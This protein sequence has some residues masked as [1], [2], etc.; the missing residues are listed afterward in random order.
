MLP[1]SRVPVQPPGRTSGGR[2]SASRPLP[3]HPILRS[4]YPG[5]CSSTPRRQGASG[6]RGRSGCVS[7]PTAQPILVIIFGHAHPSRHLTAPT[8]PLVSNSHPETPTTAKTRPHPEDTPLP[9]LSTLLPLDTLH[10][11][12]PPTPSPSRPVDAFPT[13]EITLPCHLDIFLLRQQASFPRHPFRRGVPYLQ[14][15]LPQGYVSLQENPYL[16]H[17]RPPTST[18]L[19]FPSP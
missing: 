14:T 2:T 11:M 18:T 10:P 6:G 3:A 5:C 19:H 16:D 17:T 4:A 12:T 15:L 9:H 1:G 7:L 8:R 13:P